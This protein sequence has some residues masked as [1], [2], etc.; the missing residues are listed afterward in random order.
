MYSNQLGDGKKWKSWKSTSPD[1]K[2]LEELIRNGE[3]TMNT[4]PAEVQERYSQ[5]REYSNNSFGANLRK[6]RE[7]IFQETMLQQQFGQ[8]RSK[9]LQFLQCKYYDIGSEY[10]FL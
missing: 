2:K 10:I 6:M 4:Q 1:G 3:V 9:Y 8:G 7:K 5:F